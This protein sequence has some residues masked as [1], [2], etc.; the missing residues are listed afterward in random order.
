MLSANGSPR[1]LHMN[2]PFFIL[3]LGQ[4]VAGVADA[5]QFTAVTVLLYS[6][7]GSGLA[8]AFGLLCSPAASLIF[9]PLA[10]II[11][12][13]YSERDLLAFI[14]AARG[15]LSMFFIGSHNV[16]SIYALIFMMSAA[17]AFFNPPCK[18][19]VAVILRQGDLARGNSVINGA[20]GLMYVLG[21]V[22]ASRM[23]NVYGLDMAFC[24][25]GICCMLSAGLF[26][27]IK[28]G[29]S[30]RARS[31]APVF[32][33]YRQVLSDFRGGVGHLGKNPRL[34]E[35]VSSGTVLY[36]GSAAIN[37]AFYQFAF[38]VL[39]VSGD[40]WGIVLSVFNFSNILAM[41]F[42]FAFDERVGRTGPGFIYALFAAVSAAWALYGV[43]GSFETVLPVLVLEGTALSVC[44]IL[45]GTH[46]QIFSGKAYLA[47]AAG[48]N[49]V[50]NNAGRLA[51]IGLAYSIIGVCGAKHVFFS[52]AAALTVFSISR[53]L[54]AKH[55][56]PR[57]NTVLKDL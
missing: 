54:S 47:R 38:D 6:L 7:T 14:S 11:G 2:V 45:L 9:S 8:T 49:D 35:V 51:G 39:R 53:L 26:I 12:D 48:I 41:F 19:L 30:K 55:S 32:L 20:V 28:G 29:H 42:T 52:C 25:S 33:C 43:A 16:I 10:G 1:R 17:G 23:M 56:M 57:K 27:L 24:A 5:L 44:G 34:R 46:L 40:E 13:K 21:P 4:A 15:V 3:L 36:M 22:A 31:H 50:A 37:I 18:R